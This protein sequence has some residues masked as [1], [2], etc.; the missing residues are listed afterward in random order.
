[1]QCSQFKNYLLK[2]QRNLPKPID[3]TIK[4]TTKGLC[5][6]KQK[7]KQKFDGCRRWI[8]FLESKSK[9]LIFLMA[10]RISKLCV[11]CFLFSVVE[12]ERIWKNIATGVHCFKAEGEENWLSS[13]TA[14]PTR[15]GKYKKLTRNW[16]QDLQYFMTAYQ[17]AVYYQ[18]IK[19]FFLD[20]VLIIILL[21]TNIPAFLNYSYVCYFTFVTLRLLL[22]VRVI[23]FNSIYLIY[24]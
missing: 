3:T 18:L 2:R 24:E 22:Y 1:M 21:A 12:Y 11:M 23:S 4:G 14:K 7:E 13:W 20:H 10:L 8:R 6:I 16:P 15:D 17:L 19:Y 9:V 5:Q